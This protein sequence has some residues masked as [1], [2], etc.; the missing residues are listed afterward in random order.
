MQITESGADAGIVNADTPEQH[1]PEKQHESYI[2]AAA[3]INALHLFKLI[4]HATLQELMP[5]HGVRSLLRQECN[6]IPAIIRQC[7]VQ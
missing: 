7:H 4:M 6:F 3:L 1:A 5:F 2:D